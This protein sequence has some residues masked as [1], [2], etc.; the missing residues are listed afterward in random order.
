MPKGR[1]RKI[2]IMNYPHDGMSKVASRVAN[3]AE[4]G[5]CTEDDFAQVVLEGKQNRQHD[6]LLYTIW[7][8][9]DRDARP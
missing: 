5:A 7:C 4:A 8:A 9:V 6:G 2:P 3:V 1:Q